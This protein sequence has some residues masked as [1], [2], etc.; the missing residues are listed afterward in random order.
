MADLA[1][2]G[3]LNKFSEDKNVEI[4]SL[5]KDFEG[6]SLLG[7]NSLAVAGNSSIFN[8]NQLIKHWLDHL[9]FTDSGPFGETSLENPKVIKGI[10]HLLT[11]EIREVFSSLI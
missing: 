7:P 8:Q 5:V 2:Q 3:I 1:N 11:S 4:T 6:V 10:Q 9:F